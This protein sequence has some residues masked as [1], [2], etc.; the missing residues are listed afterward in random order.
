MIHRIAATLALIAAAGC[1]G[2]GGDA[3]PGHNHPSDAA[4]T[5]DD[6]AAPGEVHDI[7]RL[8]VAGA[9]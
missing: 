7:W 8:K 1:T 4:V 9:T 2:T 5:A 3:L 6:G